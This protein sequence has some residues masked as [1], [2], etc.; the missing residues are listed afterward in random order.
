[1][2][3]TGFVGI[4]QWELFIEMVNEVNKWQCCF[5]H[6]CSPAVM[7]EEQDSDSVIDSIADRAMG[8]KNVVQVK[9]K[10]FWAVPQCQ[11]A[12]TAAC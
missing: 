10:A 9:G 3:A 7:K 4:N 12:C 6:L 2:S 8:E 11:A 5:P 1:M